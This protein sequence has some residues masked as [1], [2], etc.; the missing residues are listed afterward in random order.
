MSADNIQEWKIKY[1][2]L[3]KEFEVDRNTW[4]NGE[5]ILCRAIVRLAIAAE[6]LDPTIDAH[7][8]Q[9]RDLVRKGVQ[10]DKLLQ[11]LDDLTETLKQSE[12]KAKLPDANMLFQF[13]GACATS[14]EENAALDQ[15]QDIYN[16]AGFKDG[17]ALF[18]A[19]LQIKNRPKGGKDTPINQP[20]SSPAK[21]GILG[22]LFSGSASKPTERVDVSALRDK[23]LALLDTLELPNNELYR[24]GHFKEQIKTGL[25]GENLEGVLDEL[26][27]LLSVAKSNI[28][29]EQK[30][31]EEFLS[32]LTGKLAEL[33][34]QAGGVAAI[35]S[36]VVKEGREMNTAFSGHVAD[37]RSS[38]Q[39][40]TDLG[41]L[42]GLLQ[43]RFDAIARQIDSHREREASHVAE[44]ERQMQELSSRLQTMELES[45]ELR[46]KLRAAHSTA[47]LD[48]LTGLP[49]R[50]AYD[51]RV[52]Q[53]HLRWRRF[54]KPLC[55]LVWDIDH[56]KSIN[57]RYG[58]QAGDKAISI[59]ARDL[60]SGVRETDFIARYGGEEFVM[61]LAG[62]DNKAAMTVAEMLRI[63]IKSCGFNSEGKPVP[64]TVSC[65][66]C[67]FKA[68][69]TPESAFKRA[70][71]ALY[72]AKSEGRDRCI[73][74]A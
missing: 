15:I 26:V 6:G 25:G 44:M 60:A 16:K 11:Q 17:K 32:S 61:L 42:K 40:A 33:E 51:E 10:T 9:V 68:G 28:Q 7:L 41:Q 46:T 74:A 53:E 65:G 14:D 64:I 48:A 24:I 73:V 67:E 4:K 50:G 12:S 35:T 18:A 59:I 63:K 58:H 69:D 43:S 52:Q 1:N 36:S 19:L 5:K 62:A 55:M 8:V 49:N 37:L 21:P 54:G 31:I 45:G 71:K 39:G 34:T 23:M 30:E 2:Q 22:K 57:D 56:F 47:L 70:D 20:V 27:D 3:A 38:A 66:I 29:K 13:L 72:Q